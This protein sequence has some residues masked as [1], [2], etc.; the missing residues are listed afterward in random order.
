MMCNLPTNPAKRQRWIG[1]AQALLV[2]NGVVKLD[3]LRDMT[4]PEKTKPTNFDPHSSM[5][6][7][8]N[9]LAAFREDCIPEGDESY[10]EQWN[11]ICTAMEWIREA[12]VADDDKCESVLSTDPLKGTGH[13]LDAWKSLARRDDCFDTM[14][15]SD[16]RAIIAELEKARTTA[17]VNFLCAMTYKKLLRDIL[18][19][20]RDRIDMSHKM[21]NGEMFWGCLGKKE[22]DGGYLLPLGHTIVLRL[23]DAIQEDEK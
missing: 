21:S 17:D 10:D 2:T 19:D 8:W 20:L 6:C 9:A 11:D 13:N 18:Q 16:L 7:V 14:V 3:D 15:P 23:H 1:Y 22:K 5:E 4:R 12:L